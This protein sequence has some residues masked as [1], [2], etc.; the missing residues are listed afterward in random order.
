[1]VGERGFE[2]PTPW[3]RTRSKSNSKC[4]TRCRLGTVQSHSSSFK[5]TED[6]PIFPGSVSVRYT[7]L[8]N[9]ISGNYRKQHRS[10]RNLSQISYA[11]P[12]AH[13]CVLNERKT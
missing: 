11:F 5:C 10:V 9:A 6:V 7:S 2:P 12:Y 8:R 3:S 4:F 13:G 1:M